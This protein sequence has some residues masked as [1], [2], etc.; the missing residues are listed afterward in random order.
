[1]NI[2]LKLY[3]NLRHLVGEEILSLDL[4]EQATVQSV[5]DYL[6]GRYGREAADLLRR[7]NLVYLLNGQNVRYREGAVTP[8]TEGDQVTIM[9]PLSGG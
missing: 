2:S 5:I 4:A 7:G 9:P 3:A 1:M 8:L 6:A